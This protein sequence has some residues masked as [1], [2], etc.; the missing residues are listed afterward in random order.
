MAP[1][2]PPSTEYRARLVF[3]VLPHRFSSKR[4]I[5]CSLR[6]SATKAENKSLVPDRVNEYWHIYLPKENDK[7]VKCAGNA[8]KKCLI[9]H[10]HLSAS[11]KEGKDDYAYIKCM[12]EQAKTCK[13]AILRHVVDQLEAYKRHLKQL[14]KLEELEGL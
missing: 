5:A 7:Y 8:V 12:K 14:M 3:C 10:V 4:E 1:H 13:E 6:P 2:N 11:A 9:H